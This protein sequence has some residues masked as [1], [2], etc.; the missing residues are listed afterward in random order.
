[1]KQTL[2]R[3]CSGSRALALIISA[4]LGVAL[5]L[6]CVWVVSALAG[7]HADVASFLALPGNPESLIR[8]FW[9]P[10]TYMFTQTSPLHLLFNMLWLLWFGRMIF[11]VRPDRWIALTY[12][13][14]GLAGAVCYIFASL[15]PGWGSVALLGSSSAVLAVMTAAAA[16]MPSRRLMLFLFGEV[17]LKWLAL[18]AVALCM[19][20]GSS[21]AAVAAHAGGVAF[22]LCRG[23]VSKRGRLNL[24]ANK[25]KIKVR[26]TLNVMK[27]ARQNDTQR[28]DE[29]LDKIRISGF[30]SLSEKE[31]N[32]LNYISSRLKN[33]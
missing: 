4:N 2:I 18:A 17:K 3:I 24:R 7:V 13:G 20:G 10:F 21:F 31:K 12:L 19:F 15:L 28:L 5:L 26:K 25:P 16:L 1:M 27:A 29:L 8:R 23:L 11:D 9:T 14:G 22:G 32:E 6:G 33:H 30:D